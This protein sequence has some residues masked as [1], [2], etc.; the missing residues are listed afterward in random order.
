MFDGTYKHDLDV[1][2]SICE[3]IGLLVAC[4]HNQYKCT[5]R[6]MHDGKK[7]SALRVGYFIS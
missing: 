2:T 1:K 4:S 6:V 3:G 7:P 5:L